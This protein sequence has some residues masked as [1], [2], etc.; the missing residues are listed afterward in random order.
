LMGRDLLGI[1]RVHELVVI[2]V[3]IRFGIVVI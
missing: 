1:G 2:G 3:L